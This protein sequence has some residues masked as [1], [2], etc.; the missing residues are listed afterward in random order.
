MYSSDEMEIDE[1][2][3][4]FK[5]DIHLNI[6]KNKRLIIID[7]I[8]KF[9]YSNIDV[10]LKRD[11]T[12][13]N[14]IIDNTIEVCCIQCEIFF[15]G[16]YINNIIMGREHDIDI[17]I[18]YKNIQLFLIRI[19]EIQTYFADSVAIYGENQLLINLEVSL[20]LNSSYNDK[21][22]KKDSVFELNYVN[23]LNNNRINIYI[24]NDEYIIEKIVYEK[25]QEHHIW[26]DL[27]RD[28]IYRDHIYG[29]PFES[30]ELLEP[31]HDMMMTK[32]EKKLYENEFKDVILEIIKYIPEYIKNTDYS[33]VFNILATI[34]QKYKIYY[35]P[36]IW[37]Y[38][39]IKLE[40]V[41]KYTKLESTFNKLV[42]LNVKKEFKQIIN[43]VNLKKLPD[44]PKSLIELKC[45][46][47]NCIKLPDLPNLL[48]HLVCVYGKL[49]EL[50]N[51]PNSLTSLACYGNKLIKL[52][53]LPNLLEFLCCE[54]NN[55]TELPNLPNSLR[56]LDCS[57]NNL[58]E[59]P[60]LPNSLEYLICFNN[61]L[62]ELPDLPN[63]LKELEYLRKKLS[64]CKD[65]F[66]IINETN[67]KNRII[68]RMTLLNKTLL[69]EHSDRI[70][71]NPQRIE[72]LLNTNE[73]DFF[74]TLII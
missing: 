38:Y 3:K 53:N 25:A 63:S 20:N 62:T 27:K 49:I 59:L 36:A 64:Y 72:R 66:K 50:P 67:S 69:L 44:L 17:Y 74:N 18:D 70:C 54:K 55:L 52:P 45:S 29:S 65:E 30:F 56:H 51:L 39:I 21:L 14:N 19:C 32:K 7:F 12:L 5:P 73:I 31:S 43:N 34:Q 57:K 40:D 71:L 42:N 60:N 26:Y 58:K 10:I 2:E 48:T 23:K 33:N 9:I 8:K 41:Y 68:K 22:Y 61:K 35:Y 37:M 46:G 11:T 47:N 6:P 15:G 24:V 16:E 4:T 1:G 28:I 13:A